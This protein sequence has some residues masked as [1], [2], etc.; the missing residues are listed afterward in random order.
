MGTTNSLSDGERY[1]AIHDST[2]FNALRQQYR[3]F[4]APAS[5]V[6]IGWWALVILLG[7]YAPGFYRQTVIA[8]VNVG[9]LAVLGTFVLVLVIAA[10]YLRHA[11]TQ[12]DPL[13]DRIRAEFEGGSR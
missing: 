5:V 11:R 6:F 1:V 10:M 3:R 9:M 13:A 8:S 2:Q 7:A 4:T 12:L